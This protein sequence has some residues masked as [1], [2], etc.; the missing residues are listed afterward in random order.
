MRVPSIFCRR[1][2][3]APRRFFDPG[4]VLADRSGAGKRRRSSGRQQYFLYPAPLVDYI[5]F[6]TNRPLCSGTSGCGV[7]STTPSTDARLAA[8]FADAPADRIVPPAVPGFP[9]GRAYPLDRPDLVAARKLAGRGIG[10]RCSTGA[11]RTRDSDA[12]SHHLGE[13]R[14]HRHR[15]VRDGLESCPKSGAMTRK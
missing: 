12:R 13:P 9:A 5:V 10:T 1:T 11:A 6:N 7:P 14:T 4:G 8:A 2:S 3:T 15:R